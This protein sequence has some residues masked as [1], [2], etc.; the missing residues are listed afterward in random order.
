MIRWGV[1]P[2]IVMSLELRTRAWRS[3]GVGGEHYTWWIIRAWSPAVRVA[4]TLVAMAI[5]GNA[6]VGVVIGGILGTMGYHPQSSVHAFAAAQKCVATMHNG[7][8]N[9][10]EEDLAPCVAKC[11]HNNE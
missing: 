10:I 6:V 5:Q 11:H 2:G 4:A 3:V 7:T 9:F 1:R 8:I